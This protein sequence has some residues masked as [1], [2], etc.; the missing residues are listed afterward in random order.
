MG[1]IGVNS[2]GETY[3]GTVVTDSMNFMLNPYFSFKGKM[4][5]NASTKKVYF[6]GGYRTIHDCYTLKNGWVELF[7]SLDPK[8]IVIPVPAVPENT[9]NGKLRVS[10]FYS[11]TE[12]TVKPGFF[13]KAENITDP[14][15]FHADGFIS[16]FPSL[17]EYR[18]CDTSKLR[19]PSI[20]GNML[21]LNT[22]RCM[23]SG[24]G[25]MEL[26]GNLGK[27]NMKSAG[28]I[29]YFS[30]VDST[31]LN[32]LSALDFFFS[33][34]AMKILAEALNASSAK[35]IDVSGINYTRSLR[36]FTGQQEAD[37]ILAELSLYGQYKK[38]PEVLDH[39]LVLTQMQMSWNK[40]LRSFV[41]MGPIGISNIGKISINKQVNGYVEIGKRRN[42]DIIN[43]YLE[44]DENQW[45]YFAYANGTMQVISSNKLFNDKLVGLKEDQRT[46]KSEKGGPKY[47]FIVGTLDKKASFLRKM[48]QA[49][50]GEE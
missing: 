43:I 27:L 10:I 30:L 45:Y 48:K 7:A 35:G 14:D 3:A 2:K 19:N 8:N 17:T 49:A 33:D 39:T 23:L 6:E 4:E 36:E 11:L 38:F 25:K 5:V 41:S 1:N 32:V 12:N 15:I 20:T 29:S 40:D 16:Y 21:T 47:Q 31:A 24:E 28:R 26:A 37:K 44:P 22:S 13:S 42:G 34:D 46:L 18:V 50:G 9:G